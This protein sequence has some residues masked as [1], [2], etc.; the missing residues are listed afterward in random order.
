[1]FV[2]RRE[3]L[4]TGLFGAGW[5]GL[6]ALATGLPISVLAN[7]RRALADGSLFNCADATRAQYLI[8][9]TSAGGDT[10]NA[11]VPGAYDEPSVIHPLDPAMAPTPITIGGQ[12]Y[13][14]AKAWGQL[15]QNV[16]DRTCFFHHATLTNSH[17]N[18]SKVLKLM[19]AI[20]RQEMFASFFCKRLA[21]CLGTVQQEP[22]AIGGET[23]SYEGRTLPVLTPVALR[24]I[25]TN[26]PG[27]LT[28]VQKIRDAD[29][30]RINAVLKQDATPAARRVIDSMVISQMQARS[31]A[32]DLLDSLAAVNNNGPS[33]QVVA[34]IALI[35]MNV[36]PVVSIH[37]GFGGDNH[38]DTDLAGETAQTIAGVATMASLQQQLEDAG[39]ADKVTFAAMN[40]FGRTLTN[41]QRTVDR[42]Q[43]GRDHYRQ[44]PL[45][46]DHRQAGAQQRDRRHRPAPQRHRRDRPAH[47][48]QQRQG[49]P[50]RR[51]QVR[52]H[53]GRGGQ[54]AGRR[55]GHGPARA[56]RD[57]HPG[58]GGAGGARV[59][60]RSSNSRPDQLIDETT[61][62]AR[63][64]PGCA[65]S[66]TSTP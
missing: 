54:D 52:G 51:H 61:H 38:N 55:R 10:L 25:L 60:L 12:S 46:G 2:T 15:P 40:V 39:L 3:A 33:G 22:V 20:K 16:L 26:A 62:R 19:G 4:L 58:Q 34:A 17:A 29:L 30:G 66:P 63:S 6:R 18:E 59:A 41:I 44:P 57:H 8:L 21:P 11:N 32:Q 23:L 7:P 56:R 14:A 64:H 27:P 24:D 42:R 13:L 65:G 47:Q 49:R 36:S 28:N 1:M 37:I 53:A 5:L 50:G 43:H 45:H 31:I 35:R 9:S 48:L